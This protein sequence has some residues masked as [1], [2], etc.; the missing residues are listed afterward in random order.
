[1][2]TEQNDN[3]VEESD[4]TEESNIDLTSQDYQDIIIA[5]RNEVTELRDQVE[6][7]S[8]GSGRKSQV[9]EMLQKYE[10]VSILDISKE[11]GISTKN[12]SSQLTYLR[13][14]GHK[15]FTDNNGRKIL[16]PKS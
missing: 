15:I 7:L 6:K 13:S 12:V 3:M 2:T 9:L 14:D 11:I 8:N 4:D 1:M 16:M 5:L 10:S